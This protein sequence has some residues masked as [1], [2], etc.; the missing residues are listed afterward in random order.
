[1][2]DEVCKKPLCIAPMLI[3]TVCLRALECSVLHKVFFFPD[4]LLNKGLELAHIVSVKMFVKNMED[5]SLY[6]KDY[7]QY[8]SIN[9]PTRTCV[10]V[11]L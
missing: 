3:F 8:F 4:T 10:Q 11:R 1:M 2:F 7:S 5:Y 6:N 9:P